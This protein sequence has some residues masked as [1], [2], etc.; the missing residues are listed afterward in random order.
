[1]SSWKLFQAVTERNEYN[2]MNKSYHTKSILPNLLVD[3]I[4]ELITQ[5]CM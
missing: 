2:T 1:M 3:N 4:A 5:T